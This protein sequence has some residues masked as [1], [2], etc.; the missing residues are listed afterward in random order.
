MVVVSALACITILLLQFADVFQIPGVQGHMW[1][2]SLS[3]FG[4]GMFQVLNCWALRTEEYSAVSKSKVMMN[5]GQVL[6]QVL[7]GFIHPGV[8]SLLVGEVAGRIT[9]TFAYLKTVNMERLRSHKFNARKMKEVMVRYKSFPLLSSWSA[10]INSLGS[11]AP[12]FFLW[13][14]SIQKLLVFSFWHRKY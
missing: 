13:Q 12:V 7:L 10:L 6:S 4:I 5:G 1:I 14:Y 8:L 9:G 11:Q 3:L 2:L